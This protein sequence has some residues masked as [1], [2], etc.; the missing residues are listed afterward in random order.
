MAKGALDIIEVGIVESDDQSRQFKSAVIGGTPDLHVTWACATGR[1]A[2]LSFSRNPPRLVSR[3][4]LPAGYDRHR[5]HPAHPDAL[6]R[7]FSHPPDS[8]E[9]AA[10]PGRGPRSRRLRLFAQTL[11]CRRARPGHSDRSLGRRGG[12]Q[13]R[14]QGYCGLLPRSRLSHAPPH[15]TRSAG[16]DLHVPGTFPAGY[17]RRSGY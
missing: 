15:R 11:P 2:L 14:G 9:P 5:A 16:S 8:R 3:Q 10:P 13:P 17:H 4:P 12:V 7:R 6:A 1:D